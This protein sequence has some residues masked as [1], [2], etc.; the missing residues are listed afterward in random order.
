MEEQVEEGDRIGRSQEKKILIGETFFSVRN[1]GDGGFSTRRV[2]DT[3]FL[4]HVG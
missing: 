1:I 4:V 2:G 3:E